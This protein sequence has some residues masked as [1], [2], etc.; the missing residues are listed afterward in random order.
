MEFV[1]QLVRQPRDASLATC[2]DWHQRGHD[3]CRGPKKLRIAVFPDKRQTSRLRA[4]AFEGSEAMTSPT[5]AHQEFLALLHRVLVEAVRRHQDDLPGLTES[6]QDGVLLTAG[7]TTRAAAGWFAEGV[8]RYGDRRVHEL[9]LNA[10]RRMVHR[11]ISPAEDVLVTLL[12][13]GCHV[14]AQANGVRDTSRDGRYHN[15]R[16][17]RTA[18]AIGLAVVADT[19]IGHRTPAL[20]PWARAEYADLLVELDQGL[21]IAREP[22]ITPTTAGG[23]DENDALSGEPTSGTT[24]AG[25]E[26]PKTKYVFASC[27]CRDRR[28]RAVTIRVAAGSWRPDVVRCTACD[29]PFTPITRRLSI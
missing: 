9:F 25:S 13:E 28:G 14:W 6:L 22:A 11:S 18:Q 7:G 19:T 26:A 15:R 5:E 8:W 12:H 23:R 24:P 16:F 21:V 17:A 2:H 20:T 29:A 4:A 3:V 1:C 27:Q 10:D